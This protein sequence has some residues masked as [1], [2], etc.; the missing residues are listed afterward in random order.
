MITIR[1]AA[2]RG[3]TNIGWLNSRHTFSFNQYHDPKHMG[4]RSLRVINDDRVAAG[5]G[6]GRHGHRDMEIIT[7][8]IAGALEHQDSTGAKAVLRPGTVQRMSAG[9]G[10]QHSEYNHSR[11]QPVHFYQ[12]WIQPA[13][14]GIAPRFEDREFPAEGRQNQWQLITSPDGREGTPPIEQDAFVAVADLA[15]GKKLAIPLAPARNAWLQV[16]TGSIALNGVTLHA[17]DGVAISEET[18]LEIAGT[19]QA[20]LILFDLA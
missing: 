16:A 11:T 1:P 2:E 15:P 19:D 4:F 5:M 8:V 9:T 10:I 20:N 18:N 13:E 7:W 3:E 17:G 14:T 12:I 6:F